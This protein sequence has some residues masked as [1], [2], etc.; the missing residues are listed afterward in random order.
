MT[1]SLWAHGG[2][3]ETWA[4]FLTEW[5]AGTDA[6]AGTEGASGVRSDGAGLPALRQ[7]DFAADTW[8][9]LRLRL[10]DALSARL[11]LCADALAG[12][13]REAADEFS[14]GRALA[15]ARSGLH[16]VR[17]LA[18]HPGLP[19]DLRPQLLKMV[20]DAT[21]SLQQDLE[22]AVESMVSEGG[23]PR[24]VEARRRTLRD[25]PLTAVKRSTPSGSPGGRTS[26]CGRPSA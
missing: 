2:T 13:L 19:E 15:Q 4:A 21:R 8:D 16:P 22:R 5:A 9:R 18:N 23:D 25:N 1:G 14:V 24:H 12:A 11:Q 3:Y 6:A 20:D 26:G 10:T 7:E 17:A